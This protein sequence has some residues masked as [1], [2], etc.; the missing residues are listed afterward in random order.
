MLFGVKPEFD[1][2][3]FL[4]AAGV[5]FVA[6][7]LPRAAEAFEQTDVLYASAYQAPDKSFGIALLDDSGALLQHM[8]LPKRGHDVVYSAAA[9]KLAVFSRRPGTFAAIMDRTMAT[10]P[11]LI[12]SP[13]NRHFYGHG[14]FSANGKLLFSTENDFDNAKGVIG[15]YDAASDFKR[16]GEFSSHGIGPHDT[17]MLPDGHTMLI[18]NGGI[19]THPDYGRS[20]LNIST[21]K[22]NLAFVDIRHGTL[23]ERHELPAEFSK[24]SIRH[25]AGLSPTQFWFA[26]QNQDSNG[27]LA[28]LIGRV[29]LGEGLKILRLGDEQTASLRGY[30]G[31]ISANPDTQTIMVTS[32]KGHVGFEISV[33]DERIV[34]TVKSND[35]CGTAMSATGHITSTGFGQFGTKTHGFHWDNHIEIIQ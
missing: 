5:G 29:Q 23:I 16:I 34:K 19:E 1:R 20:K 21:M 15:I 31:S 12:T 25:L 3:Q 11:K 13:P 22:P 27:G 14:C 32:P 8:P 10:P 2:R 28:P 4:K 26:C 33:V 9:Q 30:V 35:I 7:L 18:A 6:S 17:L 24:L